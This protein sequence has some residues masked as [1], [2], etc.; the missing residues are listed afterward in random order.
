MPLQKPDK[1][2]RKY[3][4]R[5]VIPATE[6]LQRV[7][8]MHPDPIR[9]KVE[10]KYCF[11]K[12]NGNNEMVL[13]EECHEWYHFRCVGLSEEAAQGAEGWRCGYCRGDPDE[14]GNRKWMLPVPPGKGKRQREAPARND[15]ETPLALGYDA[16]AKHMVEVGPRNWGEIVQMVN[17]GGMKINVEEQRKKRK[18]EKILKEGGHH[19]VDELAFGGVGQRKVDGALVDEL[20]ELDLLNSE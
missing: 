16:S 3:P 18:A 17:E 1:I 20:E 13:C 6:R 12:T 2:L 7:L 10:R 4:L 8:L 19:V 9:R 11:C 14:R 15:D 5:K